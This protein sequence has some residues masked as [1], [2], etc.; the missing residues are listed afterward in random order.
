MAI[1]TKFA[2]QGTTVS[3]ISFDENSISDSLK[4]AVYS[5]GQNMFGFYLNKVSD[6][7]DTPKQLFGSVNERVERILTSYKDTDRSFGV[8]FSGAK[9]SGKTM[10]SSVVANRAIEELSIPVVMVEEDFDPSAL[11]SFIQKLG[12]CVLFFDEFG[13]RYNKSNEGQGELLS[14]FDGTSIGKR[15]IILT[16]NS[17]SD[18]N[19]YMLNRPGRIWYH[20]EYDKIEPEIIDEYCKVQG[21]EEDVVEKIKLRREKAY[22]FSFDVLQALVTE[23]KRYGGDIDE[24]ADA[25][26][27]E[28][29]R[30]V[31]EPTALV[32]NV[33]DLS[34]GKDVPFYQANNDFPTADRA[35]AISINRSEDNVDVEKIIKE[36]EFG[37]DCRIAA[38]RLRIK[39]LASIEGNVYTF[40]CTNQVLKKDFLVRVLKESAAQY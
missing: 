21:I 11:S 1:S 29:V 3:V 25:L 9:G 27:I 2:D 16:E 15:L 7:M 36:D 5:V 39:D 31:K 6:K 14:L 8:L 22:E 37:I 35:L 33:T 13:K 38:I 30:K 28:K 23:Y 19:P 17:K 24:L 40:K 4:P 26:N 20:F 32:L 34:T 10:C 18:I 12:E